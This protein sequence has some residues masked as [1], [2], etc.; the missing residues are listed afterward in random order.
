MR[1]KESRMTDERSDS[2]MG[3]EDLGGTDRRQGGMSGG[4]GGTDWTS[5]GKAGEGGQGGTDWSTGGTS[6]TEEM[7]GT[8]GTSGSGSTDTGG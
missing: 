5:G 6:G 3:S 1:D 7:P 2:D 4:Q 8:G